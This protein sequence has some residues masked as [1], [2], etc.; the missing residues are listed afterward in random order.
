MQRILHLKADTILSPGDL[1][2]K[3]SQ[4]GLSQAWT[5][6]EEISRELGCKNLFCTLGNHD[7]DSR[8]KYSSDPFSIPRTI[9]PNF[10][11]RDTTLKDKYWSDGFTLIEED[12]KNILYLIIN[13]V[14]DHTDELTATRGS[15]SS[16]RIE[17]LRKQLSSIHLR[18]ENQIRIALM[19][20]HP[21]QHSFLDYGS[22][23]IM[24][25][26]DQLM[27]LLSEY[28]FKIC[29]HGHRHQPRLRRHLQNGNGMLVFASGSFSAMLYDLG[30]T[31][32]NLFHLIHLSKCGS[33]FAGI[34]ESWE[35]N[36]GFGWSHS[37]RKSASI[38]HKVQ[39][40]DIFYNIEPS[41]FKAYLESE[42]LMKVD[43]NAIYSRFPEFEYYLPD[44]IDSIRKELEI[45]YGVKITLDE[46][47]HVYEM[48]KI[49]EG[50]KDD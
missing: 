33:T 29:I 43:V 3:S 49:L 46:D 34:I 20:H 47:G 38:P 13:S 44:E 22:E 31:T 48:G 16:H 11:F 8:K 45:N 42:N 5:H 30:S 19:H 27:G 4:E 9:H 1:T 6:L 41:A 21:I 36:H 35:Y 14:A 37:S 10:I 40:K 50:C 32:R 24:S 23:D 15:F 25:Y 2:N 39:F 18:N 7:V 12:D 26:G 17:S 28:R